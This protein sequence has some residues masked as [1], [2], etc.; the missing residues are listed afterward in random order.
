MRILQAVSVG[1]ITGLLVGVLYVWIVGW[2]IR[3][4]HPE[5]GLIVVGGPRLLLVVIIG[6]VVGFV[7]MLYR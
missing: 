5:P 3:R 4:R 1:L 7:W 6:F 2:S